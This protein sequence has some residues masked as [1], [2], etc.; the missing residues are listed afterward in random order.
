MTKLTK[1]LGPKTCAA[2]R[3]NCIK[4]FGRYLGHKPTLAS[5]AHPISILFEENKPS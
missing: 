3:S 2:I 1:V 4:R 5:L